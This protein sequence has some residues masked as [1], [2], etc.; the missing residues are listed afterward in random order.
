MICPLTI[1]CLFYICFQRCGVSYERRIIPSY[2]NRRLPA[3]SGPQAMRS[4]NT[5]RHKGSKKECRKAFERKY[6]TLSATAPC[7]PLAGAN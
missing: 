5:R 6:D 3:A 1:S 7:P 4:I 2:E